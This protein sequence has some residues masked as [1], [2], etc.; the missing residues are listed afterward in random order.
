M[1]GPFTHHMREERGAVL[2]ISLLVMMLLVVQGL[3]FLATARTEGTIASN[4]SSQTQTFYAAEAGLESGLVDL[5]TVLATTLNPTDAQLALIAPPALTDPNYTF[6][7]FQIGRIRS[8]PPYA[9]PT[10]ID[11]GPY[12]GLMAQTTDYIVTAE[13]RGPRQS[14]ARLR[15]VVHHLQI[16]LFQFGVFYG[17]GV[18]LEIAPGPPMTFNGRVHANS[19]IYVRHSSARF[20][21]YMTTAGNIYRYI[22]REPGV[23]GS[24]PEIKDATGIYQTLNFDHAH[25]RDFNNPWTAQDWM[26][27]ATGTFGG[28]IRDSAMGVKELIPLIPD[29][30]YDPANPEV[31]SH[32]MIEKGTPLDS[33]ELQAAK[34]YYQADLR[35]VNTSGNGKDKN[36]DVVTLPPDVV[37]TK[38]FYDKREEANILVLEVDIGALVASGKAPANG[39]LYV[40][41]DGAHKGVRLVN[42]S[43]LP[44][45][46][47]TVVSENPVY[48]QGNYNTVNKQPAAVLADAITIL[49]NNWGPHDSDNTGKQITSERPATDTTVNAAFALGPSGE[50]KVDQGNGQLENVIRFLEDWNGINFNY[51]G[52]IIA[53]WHSQQAQGDWRCCGSSGNNYYR[54]PNRNWAYDPLFN[55]SLP[56]GTPVAILTA[57]GPWSQG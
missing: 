27:A 2:V 55:T 50:S 8:T 49:S 13:A 11:S 12:A 31:I 18:D 6:S 30:F 23:R 41:H 4:F 7:M 14:R 46:G 45:G 28:L 15:Q 47:L 25:D 42:G 48:I 44:A 39:I 16:P 24:N 21:S 36:G 5:R 9:Y 26:N 40:H 37:V 10:T 53:L 38:T 3:A 19:N 56:P 54:P 51:N 33:P 34:L 17:R 1:R 32:Q 29:L 35:I 22:K 43:Q 57:K 52:S 20:D